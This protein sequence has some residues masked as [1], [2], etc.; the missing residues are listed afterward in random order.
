MTHGREKGSIYQ[1]WLNMKQRC[2]NSRHPGYK[3]YGGRGIIICD[4]WINSYET[5]LRDVGEKPAPSLTLERRD[6]NGNY[7]LNNCYWAS[8]L[9]QNNNQRRHVFVRL[10]GGKVTLS[11]ACR[12]LGLPYATIYQRVHKLGW[13]PELA[14]NVTVKSG[15]RVATRA[16]RACTDP[17]HERVQ[18]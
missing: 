10:G 3:N 6:V 17:F 12:S 16:S 2:L 4:E 18:S 7:E 8:R 1:A 13:A 11:S 14:I 5:F 15:T 9:V